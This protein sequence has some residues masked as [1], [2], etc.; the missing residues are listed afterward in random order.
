MKAAVIGGGAAGLTLAWLLSREMEVDLYERKDRLGDSLGS[1]VFSYQGKA[2][3]I[4]RNTTY[5][6]PSYHHKIDALFR[7][8]NLY[9]E[10]LA[11]S[12]LYLGQ[13]PFAAKSLLFNRPRFHGFAPFGNQQIQHTI[14][15][16][17]RKTVHNCKQ[18]IY[19]INLMLKQY[20]SGINLKGQTTSTI[21]PS[22]IGLLWQYSQAEVLGMAAENITRFLY[23]SGLLNA[24]LPTPMRF[25]PAGFESYINRVVF[26]GK[27]TCHVNRPIKKIKRQEHSVL[28]KDEKGKSLSYDQVFL[29]CRADKILSLL[30]SPS[31][32]EHN[33]LTAIQYAAVS[34]YLHQDET[35]IPHLSGQSPPLFT[36]EPYDIKHGSDCAY[37]INLGLMQDANI[38]LYIS[39]QC[40]R[41]PA[42]EKTLLHHQWHK[43]QNTRT[44]LQAMQQLNKLQGLGGVWHCSNDNDTSDMTTGISAA[45]SLVEKMELKLPF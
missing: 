19:P 18:N 24:K 26:K 33:A 21:L 44:V 45:L 13:N 27:F 16:F 15:Q 40:N 36:L 31:N 42:E 37:H 8:L 34:Y 30:D 7:Y 25:I 29:A 32:E 9:T 43:P 3:Q 28:I 11:A 12:Y 22:L 39:A 4:E 10:P 2:T 41:P 5:Y 6:F 14:K 20:M 23:T 17:I 35:I 38:P 1:Y